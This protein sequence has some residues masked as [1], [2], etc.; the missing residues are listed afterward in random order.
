M[1]S[2]NTPTTPT[3]P[4]TPT[5]PTTSP[6]RTVVLATPT[7]PTT[8]PPLAPCNLS[9]QLQDETNDTS[10]SAPSS[11]VVQADFW[12]IVKINKMSAFSA[13]AVCDGDLVFIPKR[14]FYNRRYERDESITDLPISVGDYCEMLVTTDAEKARVNTQKISS[15]TKFFGLECYPERDVICHNGELIGTAASNCLIRATCTLLTTGS[16]YAVAANI[17][18]DNDMDYSKKRAFIPGTDPSWKCGGTLNVDM[19]PFE[20]TNAR[21]QTTN[22]TI[23]EVFEYMP[24]PDRKHTIQ[25]GRPDRRNAK[26][27]TN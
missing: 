8:T 1:T 15:N 20:H 23:L 19:I 12:Q 7:S 11:P 25:V 13:Y 24:P 6:A 21:G 3:I 9:L 27:R 5:T 4:T 17:C 10:T 14:A 26:H 22:F 16:S 2:I 18:T